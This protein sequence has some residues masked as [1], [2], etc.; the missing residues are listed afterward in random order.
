MKTVNNYRNYTN[1]E[2][3]WLL[4]SLTASPVP[5]P[6]LIGEMKWDTSLNGSVLTYGYTRL[7]FCYCK[8]SPTINLNIPYPAAEKKTLNLSGTQ[9]YSNT[10]LVV[11]V[12]VGSEEN[13]HHP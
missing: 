12:K 13:I 9:L 6:I 7:K 11:Q 2:R 1:D 4:L 5:V 3:T 10:R 8:S